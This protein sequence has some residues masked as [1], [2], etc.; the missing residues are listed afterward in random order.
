[1]VAAA[2]IRIGARK[3]KRET[4]FTKNRFKDRTYGN[5]ENAPG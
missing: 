2:I 5:P 4:D 3:E 1:M